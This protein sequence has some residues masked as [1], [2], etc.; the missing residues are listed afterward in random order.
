LSKVCYQ[1]DT[2]RRS[3]LAGN[4]VT[5][6]VPAGSAP[7]AGVAAGNG[8]VGTLAYGLTSSWLRLLAGSWLPLLGGP[9]AYF[10]FRQRCRPIRAGRRKPEP[11]P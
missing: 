2:R 5:K 6:L 1:G 4:A 9:I 7:G 10:L 3:G 8:F 11:K